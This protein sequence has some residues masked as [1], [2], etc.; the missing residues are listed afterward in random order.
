[1]QQ[2]LQAP[3]GLQDPLEQ[4]AQCQDLQVQ[5]VLQVQLVLKAPKV[6]KV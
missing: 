6:F 1:M 3:Q 5:Q 4:T 2:A